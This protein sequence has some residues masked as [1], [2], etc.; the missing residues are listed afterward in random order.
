MV[1]PCQWEPA[2]AA[3]AWLE[4]ITRPIVLVTTSSDFQ[5]DGRL[6]EVALEALAAEP[7]FVVA[8][9]PARDPARFRVPANARVERF[10]PHGP[11]LDRPVCP[12]THRGLGAT[13]KGLARAVPRG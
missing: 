4:E 10:L 9:L 8:P 7:V 13:P 3:P 1:G 2:A 12:W 6:I 11:L 5:N